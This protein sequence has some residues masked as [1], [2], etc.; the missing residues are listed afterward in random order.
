M[1]IVAVLFG[2]RTF[3]I[4]QQV[5]DFAEQQMGLIHAQEMQWEN[6]LLSVMVVKTSA[7]SQA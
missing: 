7:Y 4:Q 3:S 2:Y 1:M 6:A 5:Y